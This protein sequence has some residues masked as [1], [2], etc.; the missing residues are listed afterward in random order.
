[1]EMS[2]YSDIDVFV[3]FAPNTA[4]QDATALHAAF[5]ALGSEMNRYNLDGT[6]AHMMY[7]PVVNFVTLS[8]TPAALVQYL[9]NAEIEEMTHCLPE[10]RSIRLSALEDPL[11]V[12]APLLRA[13]KAHFLDTLK[14]FPEVIATNKAAPWNIKADFYRPLQMIAGYYTNYRG[15]FGRLNSIERVT[16]LKDNSHIHANLAESWTAALNAVAGVRLR[17]ELASNKEQVFLYFPGTQVPNGKEGL[18]LTE[19]E[20]TKLDTAVRTINCLRTKARAF[21]N[22]PE[23][24]F[25]KHAF[26]TEC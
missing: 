2:P 20:K 12:L 24:F 19:A 9:A 10:S 7:C 3:A 15:A 4:A 13:S 6:Y 8:N 18:V 5:A 23:P 22:K 26:N 1:M 11:P 16:W 21:G 17:S 25:G 14:S